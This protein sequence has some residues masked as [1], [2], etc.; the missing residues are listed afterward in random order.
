MFKLILIYD[1]KYH[2]KG[3][4][5]IREAQVIDENPQTRRVKIS[6]EFLKCVRNKQQFNNCISLTLDKGS[7]YN[8]EKEVFNK[9]FFDL[10]LK[11]SRMMYS[12][13]KALRKYFLLSQQIGRTININNIS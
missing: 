4:R 7:K 6:K 11:K 12:Y 2:W 9:Y 10:F 3:R 8:T 13:D 5:L 1:T